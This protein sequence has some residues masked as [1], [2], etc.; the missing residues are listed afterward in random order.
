M[1]REGDIV[2][3]NHKTWKSNK[4]DSSG[5]G[6]GFGIVVSDKLAKFGE[7]TIKWGDCRYCEYANSVLTLSEL[8]E[9]RNRKFKK[10]NE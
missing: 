9:Q 2:V 3:K 6:S 10:I 8:I 4:Y 1:L 5:R 7:V